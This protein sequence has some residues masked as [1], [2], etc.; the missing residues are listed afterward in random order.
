M[1]IPA[2]SNVLGMKH[3]SVFFMFTLC[4]NMVFVFFVVFPS[5][6][7]ACSVLAFFVWCLSPLAKCFFCLGTGLVCRSRAHRH[8]ALFVS[9]LRVWPRAECTALL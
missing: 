3:A 2:E 9:V 8:G 6:S 1:Y 7:R 5:M 4:V